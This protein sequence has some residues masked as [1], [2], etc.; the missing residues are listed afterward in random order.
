MVLREFSMSI[1]TAVIFG[2]SCYVQSLIF[3]SILGQFSAFLSIVAIWLNMF[4]YFFTI[5]S[6]LKLWVAESKV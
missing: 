4:I 1:S 3:F 6:T 5:S 2:L